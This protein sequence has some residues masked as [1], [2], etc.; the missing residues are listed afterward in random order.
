MSI[1]PHPDIREIADGDAVTAFQE[2][3]RRFD[4]LNRSSSFQKDLR[5]V[6]SEHREATRSAIAAL[7]DVLEEF[8]RR[9]ARPV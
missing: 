1:S 8:R 4:K 6:S 3:T 9:L 5:Y 2:A 7:I